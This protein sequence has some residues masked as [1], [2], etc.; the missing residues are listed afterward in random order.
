MG[1]RDIVSGEQ[2]CPKTKQKLTSTILGVLAGE[3]TVFVT[4]ATIT[5]TT[6]VYE[7]IK[8]LLYVQTT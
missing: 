2:C 5:A 6:S 3:N 8:K 1:Q 4:P 7:N